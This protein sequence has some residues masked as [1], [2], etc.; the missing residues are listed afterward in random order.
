MIDGVHMGGAWCMAAILF[1]LMVCMVYSKG[2]HFLV[3]LTSNCS[4]Q[5]CRA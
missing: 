2:M 3:W 4:H 5:A 1:R